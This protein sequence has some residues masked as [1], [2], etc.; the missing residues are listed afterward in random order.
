MT[1]AGLADLRECGP[2]CKGHLAA[3]LRQRYRWCT[4]SYR[5]PDS[6]GG[7]LTLMVPE[8]PVA[9]VYARPAGNGNGYEVDARGVT[10]SAPF[11]SHCDHSRQRGGRTRTTHCSPSVRSEPGRRQT[12]ILRVPHLR[13]SPSWPPA[14]GQERSSWGW[15]QE[16]AMERRR[17][18]IHDEAM[19]RDGFPRG[20]RPRIKDPPTGTRPAQGRAPSGAVGSTVQASRGALDSDTALP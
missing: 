13:S 18:S 11:R 8:R 12:R 14:D 16:P 5:P 19:R 2:R 10:P 17:A 4:S 6:V 3:R 1:V 20:P 15:C 9:A 7:R